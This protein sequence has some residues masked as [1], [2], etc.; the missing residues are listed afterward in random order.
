[1]RL[2]IDYLID[3]M[4]RYTTSKSS[5]EIDEQDAP[6]PDSGGSSGGGKNN[7]TTWSSIVGSKLTRGPAN[8][9]SNDPRPDKVTRGP[10]NQ[11]K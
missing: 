3:L 11:L 8:P 6:A 5:K 1:M 7:P 2:D 10:A 9:I 4:E